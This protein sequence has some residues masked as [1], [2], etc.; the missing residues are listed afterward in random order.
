MAAQGAGYVQRKLASSIAMVHTITMDAERSMFRLQE[1]GGPVETDNLY[2]TDGSEQATVTLKA[3]FLDSAR[4]DGARLLLRK[5]RLPERNY[6]LVVHREFEKEKEKEGGGG[7]GGGG[8][9]KKTLKVV[10]SAL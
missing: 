1:K 10:R 5:V 2:P 4:W 9:A 8:G 3:Q 6:E 7:G